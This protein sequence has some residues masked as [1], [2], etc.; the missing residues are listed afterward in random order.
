M[1]VPHPP[2]ELE[3]MAAAS[4]TFAMLPGMNAE[5][6]VKMI[7]E[8]IDL[9]VQQHTDAQIKTS[10]EVTRILQQKRETD[11]HRLEQIRTEL[12]RFLTA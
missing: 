8:L 9:K 11:R 1:V 12:V 6:F 5:I 10:P 7:E 3:T 4:T 2:G